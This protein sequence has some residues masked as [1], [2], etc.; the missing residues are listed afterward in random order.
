MILKQKKVVITGAA[1]LVGQNLV[2]YLRSQ[3]YQ[4]IIAI[5]KHQTNL[6]ILKK[7]NPE[8]TIVHADLSEQGEWGKYVEQANIV[9]LLH[10]QITGL[11]AEDFIQNNL[12]A[13]ENV[14][15]IIKRHPNIYIIH[16]SSSVINTAA[17]DLYT[18]TKRQQE[19][20]VLNSGVTFC[21]LRPTLM[22]GWFDQK[23][24]GWISRFMEKTPFFPIP[25]HGQYIRQPLYSRDFCKILSMV[26]EKKPIN[27]IYDIVGQEKITYIDIIKLIKRTKS[28]KTIIVKIPY[29]LFYGLLKCYPL[30]GSKPPFTAAQLTALTAGDC[31]TGIDTNIIFGVSPT[32]LSQAIQETFTH[33]IY[34]KIVLER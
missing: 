7:I 32:T 26:I 21:L 2:L 34:S 13:T 25:G 29:C 27:A 23:H 30:I 5:D 17:N 15:A 10:A 19:Q 18:I 24:L 14:L 33:P 11:L 16:V 4:N 20:M 3:G 28:L 1:G 22:F 9:I 31:F 6:S 8:I 12:Q